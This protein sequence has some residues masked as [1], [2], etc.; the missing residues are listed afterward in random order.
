VTSKKKYKHEQVGL[1]EV[2][3]YMMGNNATIVQKR[4][5]GIRA[6]SPKFICLNDDMNKTHAPPDDLLRAIDEFYS[7]FFPKPSPFE[8]PN[9]QTNTFL[10]L[11]DYRAAQQQAKWRSA[12]V[13]VVVCIVVFC[14]GLVMWRS[15]VCTR[16]QPRRHPRHDKNQFLMV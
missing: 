9:G 1:D 14:V 2:E 8:L 5:D 3:F 7:S 15:E 4:L 6:K 12:V 13:Y 11:D 10:Y 16:S